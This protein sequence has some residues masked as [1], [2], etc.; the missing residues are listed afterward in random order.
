MTLLEKGKLDDMYI[1]NIVICKLIV[2][3]ST[4]F[5]SE[6]DWNKVEKEKIMDIDR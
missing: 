3:P 5:A 6:D 4:M 1:E 2:E